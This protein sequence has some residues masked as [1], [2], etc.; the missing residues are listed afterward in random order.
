MR[1]WKLDEI[2]TPNGT[3]SPV[4]LHSRD[5]AER[6]V[7]I[8]LRPG[9]A[10]GDHQVRESAMLVVVG[11]SVRV[12]SGDES[13]DAGPGELF[14]FEPGERHSVTSKSGGSVLLFLAPWPARVSA[15]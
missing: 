2:E 12:D 6:V 5:G 13:I 15:S 1:H 9:D 8:E 11:G 7:L 14:H 10:L 4:V 3:R